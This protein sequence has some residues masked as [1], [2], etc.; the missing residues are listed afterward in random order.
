MQFSGEG[1]L[2]FWASAR[3]RL[4]SSKL[5][6]NRKKGTVG[7]LGMGRHSSRE[8]PSPILG[9]KP[10]VSQAAAQ[11]S[12]YPTLGCPI[13]PAPTSQNRGSPAEEAGAPPR[14]TFQKVEANQL[15]LL[16]TC[17]KPPRGQGSSSPRAT[18][19][20]W[21]L[22]KCRSS[23]SVPT[24]RSSPRGRGAPSSWGLP[25]SLGAGMWLCH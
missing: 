1:S 6:T 9:C 11:G 21:T 24:P 4:N 22:L 25:P 18:P 5:L 15:S 8:L 2:R 10:A 19:P 16:G 14:G 23:G 12:P 13:C 20:T 3:R 17:R 7:L